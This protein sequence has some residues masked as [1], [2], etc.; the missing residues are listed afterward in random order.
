VKEADA[1]SAKSPLADRWM[2][3]SIWLFVGS[4]LLWA[5][6]WGH[7]ADHRLGDANLASEVFYSARWFL[8]NGWSSYGLPVYSTNALPYTHLTP[9]PEY[10]Q[11]LFAL[12]HQLWPIRLIPSFQWHSFISAVVDLGL[13][14]WAG[15]LTLSWTGVLFP[16]W[17]RGQVRRLISLVLVLLLSAGGVQVFSGHPHCLSALLGNLLAVWAALLWA[18]KANEGAGHSKAA[19]ARGVLGW[20]IGSVFGSVIFVSFWLGLPPVAFSV[21]WL[22]AAVW[23][24]GGSEAGQRRARLVRFVVVLGLALAAALALKL[25]QN[26]LFL[27]SWPEVWKDLREIMAVRQGISGHSGYSLGLHLLKVLWRQ[28]YLFGI[29]PTVI[30]TSYALGRR[31]MPWRGSFFVLIALSAVIWQVAMRQHAFFHI[32][33][34]REAYFPILLFSVLVFF[35]LE[36]SG[37]LTWARLRKWGLLVAWAQWTVLWGF[38]LLPAIVAPR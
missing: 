22:F 32:Y 11:V 33:Y 4:A 9:L 23:H 26:R 25:W 24:F 5:L 12:I 38:W 19:A 29:L 10:I 35:P 31:K 2:G 13:L 21:L 27:G 36:G 15:R 37:V 1:S 28:F 30:L 34:L 8:E 7:S 6:L 14:F 3:V 17:D 20:G 18:R 16:L